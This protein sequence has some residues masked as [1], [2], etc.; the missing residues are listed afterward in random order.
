M[1]GYIKLPPYAFLIDLTEIILSNC[2]RGH[3]EMIKLPSRIRL[4]LISEYLFFENDV[5][6][7]RED[8]ENVSNQDII[9]QNKETES[10]LIYKKNIDKRVR[11]ITNALLDDSDFKTGKNNVPYLEPKIIM[12]HPDLIDSQIYPLVDYIYHVHNLKT[13]S[14]CSG[15]RNSPP[16]ISFF[17]NFN[18]IFYFHSV[19]LDFYGAPI[20]R[21][22]FLGSSLFEN[23]LTCDVFH[24]GNVSI[25]LPSTESVRSKKN[26][27]KYEIIIRY[28]N[29]VD[30]FSKKEMRKNL[31]E[32]YETAIKSLLL[33]EKYKRANKVSRRL[34]I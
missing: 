25:T 30:I 5:S 10:R 21:Y 18:E 34:R 17:M 32:L 3:K 31:K 12:I 9:T 4:E 24:L 33:F 8:Q 16:Y 26:S 7:L 13:C 1:I 14:S 28:L 19:L 22:L 2:A 6:I 27:K 29:N 15:H 11:M 23:G 20:D